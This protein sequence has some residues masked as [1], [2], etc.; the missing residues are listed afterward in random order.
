MTDTQ[1]PVEPTPPA[2]TVPEPVIPQKLAE[3]SEP[4]RQELKA[5][6]TE[7][8]ARELRTC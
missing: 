1:E 6:L 8:I 7:Q 3:L 2:H 4:V 5:F